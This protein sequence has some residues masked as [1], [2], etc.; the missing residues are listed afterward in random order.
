MNTVPY[1]FTTSNIK[2]TKYLKYA[3]FIDFYFLIC[4]TKLVAKLY[5]YNN[6]KGKISLFFTGRKMI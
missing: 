5:F 1:Y 6:V 4:Y 3:I 2:S